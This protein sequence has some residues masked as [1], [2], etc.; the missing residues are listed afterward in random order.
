[1]GVLLRDSV[2]LLSHELVSESAALRRARK[3]RELVDLDVNVCLLAGN[4]GT[5]LL[6]RFG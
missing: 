1:M 4:L 5:L 6:K 2:N 3:R